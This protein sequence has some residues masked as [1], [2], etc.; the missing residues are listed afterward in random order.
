MYV[1]ELTIGIGI[2]YTN[3]A[4]GICDFLS[5]LLKLVGL[6][7]RRLANRKGCSFIPKVEYSSTVAGSR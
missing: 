4:Y 1:E 5:E 2:R 6:I 7:C 3:M